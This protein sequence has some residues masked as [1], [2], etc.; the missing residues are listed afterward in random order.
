MS[1]QPAT[2]KRTLFISLQLKLLVAFTVLFSVVFA[3]A[4]YWF[5]RF[6]TAS[7]LQRIREDMVDTLR[8]AAGGVN[9]EEMLA[10]AKDGQARA[11]GFSDDP[12]YWRQINW[13]D[14]INHVEPRAWPYVYLK[15][16]GPNQV[17]FVA[18]L[19][20]KY[21]PS[22]STKFLE[23]YTSTGPL[24]RGLTDETVVLEPYTDPWGRWVSAYTPLKNSRGEV[25]GGIGLDFRADYVFQVQQAILNS[26]AIAF[27]ITYALLFGM[28]YI[29]ARILTR[30][31]IALTKAAEHIGEGDY[32]QDLTPLTNV[33]LRDEISS[34]A[35]VFS[36]MVGKVYQREQTLIRKVEELKIEID[37]VKRKK[38]VTEIVESDTFRDLQEKAREMRRRRMEEEAPDGSLGD[39]G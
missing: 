15:G 21:D 30:P 6:A 19:W 4:Y 22:K 7:A 29:T 39:S 12:R 32:E 9:Q 10:L 33:R 28:V 35:E 27:V 23:P 26:V 11:D 5:Y 18:D 31:I 20:A 13:L 17:I 24:I 37:E 16:T 1:H 2:P 25:I 3:G 38:Q 36:I 14:S 8:A 34:L